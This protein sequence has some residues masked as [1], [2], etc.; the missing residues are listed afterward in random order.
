MSIIAYKIEKGK[1]TVAC[2]G[3][4]LAGDEIIMEDKVKILKVPNRKIICGATGLS[5]LNDIWRDFVSNNAETIESIRNVKSALGLGVEF[6]D[7]IIDNFHCGD[8]MFNEFGGFFFITPFFHC[9]INYD[10]DKS[11]YI[12]NMCSDYGCFGA[13]ETYTGALLD[14]GIDIDEAIKMTAKKFITVNDNVYELSFDLEHESG[15]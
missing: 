7:C 5:D 10:R 8:E 6:K 15:D 9:V 2:D 3:R 1:I 13:T 4:V 14:A 11:P 12:T